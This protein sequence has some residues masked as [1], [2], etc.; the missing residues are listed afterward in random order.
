MDATPERLISGSIYRVPDQFFE[1]DS[2]DSRFTPEQA[3]LEGDSWCSNNLTPSSDPPWL[4]VTFGMDVNISII[5]TGGYS[6]FFFEY[7]VTS[8]EVYISDGTEESLRPL[9]MPDNSTQLM[10]R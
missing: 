1:A 6:R 10:V 7:Y 3:R 2:V 4:Q 8:F 9:T 5:Q